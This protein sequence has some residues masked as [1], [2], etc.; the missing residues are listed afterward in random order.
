MSI[1]DAYHRKLVCLVCLVC[2]GSARL[3][4]IVY[5]HH[6]IPLLTSTL[7]DAPAF[8]SSTVTI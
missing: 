4:G 2:L 1:I 7:L 6:M 8:H 3:L 5:R